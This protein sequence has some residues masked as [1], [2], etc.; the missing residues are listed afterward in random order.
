MSHNLNIPIERDIVAPGGRIV[1]VVRDFV[2]QSSHREA[3]GVRGFWK[4]CK[5]ENEGAHAA[6][7]AGD[8][9]ALPYEVVMTEN[10]FLDAGI[11]ELWNVL[12]G[13]STNLWSHVNCQIG[14]GDSS[15]AFAATQTGLQASTNLYWQAVD[16]G[17]PTVSGQSI[18]FQATIG[19]TS[20]LYTWNEMAIK[21]AASGVVL[22]RV[23][24]NQGTKSGSNV[25]TA[26]VT[27][28]AS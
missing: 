1:G 7:L 9:E 23:V 22:N 18:T 2:A 21:N 26:Q 4:V 15:T 16:T 17:F 25:W 20:A 27:V 10:G 28:T 11:T 13:G 6:S 5:F 14:I 3:L 24:Q 8:P 12:T 19:A